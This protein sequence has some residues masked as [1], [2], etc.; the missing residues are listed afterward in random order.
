MPREK[1]GVRFEAAER[2]DVQVLEVVPVTTSDPEE[3]DEDIVE[4]DTDVNDGMADAPL[5]GRKLWLYPAEG[6]PVEGYWKLT[7]RWNGRIWAH[8][9]FWA[10]WRG[11]TPV[12]FEPVRWVEEL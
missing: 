1:L 8:H 6:G 7:R 12:S 3:G 11:P 4:P 10:I 9:S 2:G 5:D